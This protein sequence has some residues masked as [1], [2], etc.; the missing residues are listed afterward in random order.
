MNLNKQLRR[1]D[2]NLEEALTAPT[3]IAGTWANYINSL[4]AFSLFVGKNG[5]ALVKEDI[6]DGNILLIY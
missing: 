3:N 6:T 4:R 2:I 5:A 1:E